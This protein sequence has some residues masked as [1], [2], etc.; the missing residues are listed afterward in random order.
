MEYRQLGRSGLKVPVLSL[1]TATFGGGTEFFKKWGTTDV[2]GARRLVSVALEAGAAMF[3]T[4]DS[5]S[6]GLSEEILGQALADHPRDRVLIS[7]KGTFRTGPGVNDIGSS[8]H[9]LVA[10]CE[11]SLRRLR[12][13][14]ID[15]YQLHGFDA[16]TPIEETVRV[17]D[18]LVRMGKVRYV[19]C[20]NFSG[21]QLMKSLAVADRH[22]WARH[23]AHQAY[24]SLAGR[25]YEWELMPLGHAEG[26]GAVVWSPLAWGRLGGRFRRNQP[27]PADSRVVATGA[28]PP[29]AEDRLFA[30]VDA[31]AAIA[32]DTGRSVAQ[33]AINWL[34]QR[35]TVATVLVG[36]RD[37]R[38]L[39]ENLGAAGWA[40]T[41]EQMAALD[42]ASAVTPVYPYWHQQRTMADRNAPLV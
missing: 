15:L 35:P 28:A 30:I 10:A 11:A 24:Y 2:A 29:I 37:E 17:L 6:D 26:V 19:G 7:T 1:G 16:V 8:R 5:Y 18:D 9:R 41:P 4:A 27:P 34:L 14:Y 42:A 3:D 40:L 32:A 39:V 33:V 12:T 21:W 31:L 38:Q 20:S 13:D 25:E 22:G 36:A 23:V